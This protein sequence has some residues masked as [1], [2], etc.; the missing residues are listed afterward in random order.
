MF[1]HNPRL[2]PGRTC[3]SP[4]PVPC[5]S[6]L[7]GRACGR[8]CLCLLFSCLLTTGSLGVLRGP[9]AGARK[10]AGGFDGAKGRRTALNPPKSPS[11]SVLPSARALEPGGICRGPLVSTCLRGLPPKHGV[12]LLGRP[13]VCICRPAGEGDPRAYPPLRPSALVLWRMWSL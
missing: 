8:P 11:S 5:T 3:V 10:V 4:R 7:S 2:S 6:L 1:A 12:L 13:T 9:G